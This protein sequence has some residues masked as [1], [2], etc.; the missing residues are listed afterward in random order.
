MKFNIIAEGH[1]GVFSVDE[2]ILATIE[3]NDCE[4]AMIIFA[5][6]NPKVHWVDYWDEWIIGVCR[7]VWV[8]EVENEKT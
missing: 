5:S 3:A 8:K 4:N 6:N 7:K 1:E 2:E